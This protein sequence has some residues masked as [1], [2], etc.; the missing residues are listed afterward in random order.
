MVGGGITGVSAA[1]EL[2]ARGVDAVVLESRAIGAGASGRNAGFLMRGAADNYAQAAEQWGR[3][4]ARELWKWTEDNLADL[5][6]MGVD[7]LPSF[8]YRPSCL[9]AADAEE[10]SQ[11]R[12]SAA[13]LAEDGFDVSLIEHG[14]AAPPPEDPV[15]RA[16]GSCLGLVNPGDAVCNPSELMA[17]LA[18]Q[19]RAVRV[20]AGVEVAT[21]EFGG[22]SGV[23][24]AT[25]RGVVHADRVLVC[26]NAWVGRLLADV[27]A[28]IEPNRGQ[29]LAVRPE[30]PRDARLAYAYYLDHGSEYV[31]PGPGGTVVF[32]GARKHHAADERCADEEPTQTV[33]DHLERMVAKHVTPRYEVVARWAGVMGFSLDEL[34]VVGPVAPGEHVWVCAGFTGH[35]MSLAHRTARHAVSAMLDDGPNPFPLERFL[36]AT[37]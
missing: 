1:L 5:V 29:M 35:G 24:L 23:R 10:E 36:P 25:S 22:G 8:E 6:A 30:D 11:L 14:S 26:T 3:E 19:L 20:L 18:A 31:R 17:H 21:I 28:I 4:R 27:A 2:E 15:W 7:G 37:E 12:T 13:M 33:Q 32:G 34:P 9:V 16:G